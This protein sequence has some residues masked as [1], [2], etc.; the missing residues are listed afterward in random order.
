MS[1][2]QN[3]EDSRLIAAAKSNKEMFGGLYSKYAKRVYGYLWRRIGRKKELAEDLMQETFLRA[4]RGLPKFHAQGYSYLTYLLRIAHNLLVNH[5]RRKG[6][7]PL[8]ESLQEYIKDDKENVAEKVERKLEAEIVTKAI[9]VLPL[10]E[11]EVVT[12]YYREELPVK[13]IAHAMAKSEN[14]IK[15]LLFRARRRLEET[16][17]LK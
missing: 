6:Y 3:H 8:D 12:R 11:K 14:A 4:F 17:L 13:E 7:V 1:A 5:Y 16:A 2:K 15:L 9:E 10:R